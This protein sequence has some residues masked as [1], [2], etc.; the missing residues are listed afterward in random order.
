MAAGPAAVRGLA[1]LTRRFRPWNSASCARWMAVIPSARVSKVTKP[2]P[3]GRPVSCSSGRKTSSTLPKLLKYSRSSSSLV[4]K[5]KLP[6]NSFILST[7]LGFCL[8]CASFTRSRRFS[9][10]LSW[11]PSMARKASSRLGMATKPKPRCLC[12]PGSKGR[13]TSLTSPKRSKCTRS[14]SGWLL[15]GRL[16]TKIFMPRGASASATRSPRSASS[17]PPSLALSGCST[18]SW[19]P[20]SSALP[21]TWPWFS[22]SVSAMSC[23]TSTPASA[24]A[25]PSMTRA[26]RGGGSVPRQ[27]LGAARRQ[28]VRD[29]ALAPSQRCA[30]LARPRRTRWEATSAFRVA[31]SLRADRNAAPGRCKDGSGPGPALLP[32]SPRSPAPP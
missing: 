32:A 18:R 13:I 7:F 6:T 24:T 20:G 5:F 3:R 29:G 23:G 12:V 9:K 22:G 10:G 19:G 2:N 8:V 30:A 14:A 4:W 17:W 27:N 1:S 21:A 11:V 25:G 31:S 26:P 15:Y 16:P 28:Q